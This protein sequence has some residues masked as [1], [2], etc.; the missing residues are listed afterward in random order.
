MSTQERVLLVL[1][2][3]RDASMTAAILE[4]NGIASHA[5]GSAAELGAE[6]ARGAGAVL[7]A[8][9]ALG[10]GA[11]GGVLAQQLD[12][13][14]P[15][16][17]L[18]VLVLA[19]QGADSHEVRDALQVLGNVTRLERP[20]RVAALLSLVRTALRARARQYQLQ[21]YLLDLEH[22]RAQQAIAARR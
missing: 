7:I 8:E 5:C 12:A 2:T 3:A 11:T 10:A 15:W 14:P 20:L 4:R 21:R 13:Q 18:P 16:T 9:E 19:R 17:D 22:A 6:L 1:P